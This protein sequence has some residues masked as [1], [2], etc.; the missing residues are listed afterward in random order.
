MRLRAA[1][2]MYGYGRV[3]VTVR[4]RMWCDVCHPVRM[5]DFV[6]ERTDD[7]PNEHLKVNQRNKRRHCNY[8]FEEIRGR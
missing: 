1:Y 6:L 5:G 3:C 2:A 4:A 8:G 7:E